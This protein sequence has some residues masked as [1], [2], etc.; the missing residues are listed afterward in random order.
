MFQK[1]KNK[2]KNSPT[3]LNSEN[4]KSTSFDSSLIRLKKN[5][6]PVGSVVAFFCKSHFFF[7]FSFHLIFFCADVVL[8]RAFTSALHVKEKNLRK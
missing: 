6:G 4:L 2:Q 1:K 7:H 3:K 5:A 8:R